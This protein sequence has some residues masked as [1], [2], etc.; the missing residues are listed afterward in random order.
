MHARARVSVFVC[1]CERERK[2]ERHTEREECFCVCLY[3]RVWVRKSERARVCV[4]VYVCVCVWKRETERH[5]ESVYMH[6][7]SMCMRPSVRVCALLNNLRWGDVNWCVT[8]L[9]NLIWLYMAVS[10]HSWR[11]TLFPWVN[12][13]PSISNWQLS[14]MGFETRTTTERG[15]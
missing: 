10:F 5:R 9:F 8:P 6:N 12:Q 3:V 15:E 7:V 13:Q 1:V 2:R 4:Y 14:L 11:N